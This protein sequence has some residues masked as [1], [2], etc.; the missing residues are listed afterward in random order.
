[1]TDPCETCSHWET[2][3]CNGCFFGPDGPLETVFAPVKK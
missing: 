1:M 3:R 2:E